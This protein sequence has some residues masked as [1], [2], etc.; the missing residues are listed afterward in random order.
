[1]GEKKDI[2][3]FPIPRK[4][5]SPTLRIIRCLQSMISFFSGRPEVYEVV[6]LST[7]R[8]EDTG[9]NYTADNTFIANR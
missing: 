2:L 1:M 5:Q 6:V 7:G 4:E 8:S 3:G 9:K